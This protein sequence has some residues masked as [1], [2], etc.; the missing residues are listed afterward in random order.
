MGIGI[1][2]GLEPDGPRTF[3]DIVDEVTA[4]RDAGIRHVWASQVLSWDA[5]TL[6]TAIGT[7]V[8]GV[9]L[10]T[11]IVPTL[12][13][14]PLTLAA[15]ALTVQAV[16]GDRLTLGIGSSHEP[17]MRG[18]FGLP[19]DR[20]ALQV[21]EHLEVLGPLLRGETV[22]H[23][24]ES[25]RAT[26]AVHVGGARPPAVLV[27]AL[28][29]VMLQVAGELSDGTIATWVGPRTLAEHIVPRLTAAATGAGRPAPRVVVSLLVQVTADADAARQEAAR[30]YG[31]AEQ[32]PSYR[33]VLDRE[34]GA[35]VA[36]VA[37][38]TV[39]GDGDE[40]IRQ[41]AR[42][43]E[44]GATEVIATPFGPPDAVTR[45]VALLASGDTPFG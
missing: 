22:D 20:P 29:P 32:L 24:G 42:L 19:F 3:G 1:T 8:P 26:G 18:A 14:H 15:Q 35:G 9:A 30:L 34:A 13:R 39:A 7:R 33:A 27:A 43:H 11:A 12:P 25:I 5:L 4:A 41:L 6:L 21:R 16:T 17:I 31:R 10:G 28:G 38:V 36:G 40:V 2:I 37:D 44:A 45:T 23:A